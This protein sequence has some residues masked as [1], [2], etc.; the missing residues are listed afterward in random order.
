MTTSTP[1][2]LNRS[3]SALPMKPAPPV[4]SA[5]CMPPSELEARGERVR[6][7]HLHGLERE[8]VEILAEELELCDQLV[9]HRDDVAADRAGLDEVQDL[10]R[11]CPDELGLR[12]DG[13]DDLERLAHD[14]HRFDPGVRD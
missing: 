9:G 5:L 11:A 10:A 6:P 4:I 13:L 14:R 12:R 8:R 1:S 3:T 2:E 7:E